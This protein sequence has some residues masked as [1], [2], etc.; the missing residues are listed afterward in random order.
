MYNLHVSSTYSVGVC[1][2]NN[3]DKYFHGLV[4]NCKL[5]FVTATTVR[6]FDYFVASFRFSV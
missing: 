2:S 4:L 1:N 6:S 5:K 3:V